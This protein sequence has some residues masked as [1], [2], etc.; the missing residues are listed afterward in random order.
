MTGFA[1]A[2]SERS[3]CAVT[4]S[5]RSVNHRLLEVRVQA[6]AELE[7][8]LPSLE[9]QVRSG[10]ARGHVSVRCLCENGA[11]GAGLRLDE[12][13]V[14]AYLAAHAEIGRRLGVQAPPIA[15]DML[16]APGV[17]VPALS[18]PVPLDTWAALAREAL[19]AALTEL[20]RM[21]ATEGAALAADLAVRLARMRAAC[22]SLSD[23]RTELEAGLRERLAARMREL[24]AEAS[25]SPE[26][27]LQEAAL[28]ASRGDISEE[29]TRLHA[30]L[31]Q[32]RSLLLAG[33]EVGKK[34]DFLTQELNREANTLLAKSSSGSPVGLQVSEIGLGLK[35]EIEKFREQVANLE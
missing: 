19:A 14:A 9:K 24:L 1:Q 30:H 33:G 8:A 15:A 29:L 28:Q 31:A 17:L 10:L 25:P 6:P 16:R 18:V 5:L 4:V 23:L 34:L 21:R 20:N 7:P 22:A 12:T 35:A 3:G 32:C 11:G 27:I 26:R 13:A 2:R